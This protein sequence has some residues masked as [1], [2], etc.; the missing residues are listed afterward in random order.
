M[1]ESIYRLTSAISSGRDDFNRGDYSY[2]SGSFNDKN[3]INVNPDDE[4]DDDDDY[5]SNDEE[6]I[7]LFIHATTKLT[8]F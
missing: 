7:N 3:E 4:G 5:G 6:V 2:S 8:N 1:K